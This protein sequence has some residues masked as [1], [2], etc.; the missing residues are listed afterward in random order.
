M[1][2]N[3]DNKYYINSAVIMYQIFKKLPLLL[4]III[5]IF[6]FSLN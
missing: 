5:N 1:R 6:N 3:G 4:L 2:I